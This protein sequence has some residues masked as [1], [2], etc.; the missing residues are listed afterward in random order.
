MESEEDTNDEGDVSMYEKKVGCDLFYLF[1]YLCG[2]KVKN[3]TGFGLG[4]WDRSSA[5]CQEN[6]TEP[7]KDIGPRPLG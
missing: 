6:D 5:L 7:Q 3:M 4:S 1:V 2:C